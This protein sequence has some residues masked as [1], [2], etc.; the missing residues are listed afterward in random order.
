MV[1]KNLLKTRNKIKSSVRLLL[2]YLAHPS[3][4]PATKPN[5]LAGARPR[6]PLQRH[7]AWKFLFISSSL[8]GKWDDESENTTTISSARRTILHFPNRIFLH[9]SLWDVYHGTPGTGW[10]E[11]SNQSESESATRLCPWTC[12]L[13]ICIGKL[14][15]SIF[16]EDWWGSFSTEQTWYF[17]HDQMSFIKVKGL[18]NYSLTSLFPLCGIC[19]YADFLCTHSE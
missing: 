15:S 19:S 1:L 7:P 8:K 10:T 11:K 18:L 9:A 13:S 14:S 12:Q 2:F 16:F 5:V 3:A 17:Q 6:V 4:K